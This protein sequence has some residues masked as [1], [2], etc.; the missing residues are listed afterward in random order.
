MESYAK[1][2][3][4]HDIR[5]TI[6]RIQILKFIIESKV[7]PSADEIYEELKSKIHAISRATVYNTVN[8]LS[9]KG[10]IKEVITP[11][12]IRYDYEIVPHHHFFCLKCKKVYDVF[13][14]LPE[15]QK[16]DSIDGHLVK[17]IQY[18][19]VGICKKCLNGGE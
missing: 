15:I 5:P 18:C 2:L 17:K 12:A 4:L 1:I 3:K 7:H 8:L 10:V 13:G 19:L 9:E 16:V 11:S 6:Q 14:E